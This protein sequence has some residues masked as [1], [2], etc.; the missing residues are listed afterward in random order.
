[1][2]GNTI[3]INVEGR[4]LLDLFKLSFLFFISGSPISQMPV[5]S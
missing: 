3:V 5:H 2:F 1:M 4:S